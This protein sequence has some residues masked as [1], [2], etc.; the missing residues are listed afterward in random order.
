MGNAAKPIN[1]K[2]RTSAIGGEL[3]QKLVI[4]G[5]PRII[6]MN[7]RPQCVLVRLPA[8]DAEASELL[9]RIEAAALEADCYWRES[10]K[11]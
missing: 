2:V 5:K 3:I 8:N 6:T 9:G 10:A 7:R 1:V 4:D 11:A